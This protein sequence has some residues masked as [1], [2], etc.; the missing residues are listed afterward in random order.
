MPNFNALTHY[1]VKGMKWGVRKRESSGEHKTARAL[2][3]K[4]ARELTNKEIETYNRRVRLEAEYKKLNPT[5]VQKGKNWMREN[6]KKF[7]NKLLE[8]IFQTA[9]NKI[10]KALVEG[11]FE[12]AKMEIDLDNLEG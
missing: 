2:G 7:E 3:K 10:G 6:R 8:V 1:G 9:A 12:A 4:R 5:R 11:A